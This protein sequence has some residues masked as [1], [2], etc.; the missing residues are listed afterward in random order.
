MPP[1]G[2]NMVVKGTS[3]GSPNATSLNSSYRGRH[4][5]TPVPPL[6]TLESLEQLSTSTTSWIDRVTF[7]SSSTH[8][9]LTGTAQR[10]T[11]E[12]LLCTAS[13]LCRGCVPVVPS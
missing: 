7:G 12:P 1:D 3:C 11:P 9:K 2:S 4:R 6:Q 8:G 10:K 13:L 5:A